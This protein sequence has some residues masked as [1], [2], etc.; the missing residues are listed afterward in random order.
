MPHLQWK[1]PNLIQPNP[2]VGPPGGLYCTYKIN[3]I[4]LTSYFPTDTGGEAY[5]HAEHERDGYPA[6]GAAAGRPGNP[7]S[8]ADDGQG[9]G[10]DVHVQPAQ[11]PQ[12][13]HEWGPPPAQGQ[14]VPDG[15]PR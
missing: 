1:S 12:P 7:G 11:R 9:V 14:D 6:A 5:P 10:P 4:I 3:F 8:G 15:P 13:P 2:N